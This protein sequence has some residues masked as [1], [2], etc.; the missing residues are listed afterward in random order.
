MKAIE[1]FKRHLEAEDRKPSHERWPDVAGG[2]KARRK[3]K[4]DFNEFTDSWA[5]RARQQSRSGIQL[6]GPR[7][8][9]G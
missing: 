5:L 9:R 8:K 4:T 1:E 7:S 3:E 2:R 6:G